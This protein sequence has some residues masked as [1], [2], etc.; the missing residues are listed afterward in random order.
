MI[1]IW[2]SQQEIPSEVK[3]AGVYFKMI[4]LSSEK[5][6]TLKHRIKSDFLTAMA[7]SVSFEPKFIIII[8]WKNMTFGNR[9]EERP[10]KVRK[11]CF[12]I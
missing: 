7:G 3:D 10:L 5:D 9:R 1:G 6:N 8:T 2:F 4:E 12:K 11:Y